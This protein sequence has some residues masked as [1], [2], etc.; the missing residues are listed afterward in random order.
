RPGPPPAPPPVPRPLRLTE[1][2]S[3]VHTSAPAARRGKWKPPPSPKVHRRGETP[4]PRAGTAPVR[5]LASWSRPRRLVPAGGPG[6][7]EG[8]PN[9]NWPRIAALIGLVTCGAGAAQ[10]QGTGETPTYRRIRA[11]ID[12]IPAIDTHDH[13]WP[14]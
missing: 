5:P 11:A 10:G 13:L 4:P 12:A 8:S 3:C 9:M 7:H 14:F 1:S 2:K 6:S